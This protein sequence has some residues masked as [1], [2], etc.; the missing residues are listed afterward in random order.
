[1]VRLIPEAPRRLVVKARRLAGQL[2]VYATNEALEFDDFAQGELRRRR[3]FYDEVLLVTRHGSVGWPFLGACGALIALLAMPAVALARQQPGDA[4]ILFGLL[5]GPLL[6]AV[7]VQLIRGSHTVTV[8]GKRSRA[9]I[10]LGIR[11]G[12]ARMVF[13]ELC[14]LVREKQ[15]WRLPREEQIDASPN[16]LFEG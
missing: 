6:L 11:A 8:W 3:M 4:L 2:R 14:K 5:D 13:A 16:R 1:V 7:L 9:R 12:R 15:D 10:P